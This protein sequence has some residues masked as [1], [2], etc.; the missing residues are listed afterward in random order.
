MNKVKNI[1]PPNNSLFP[2]ARGRAAKLDCHSLSFSLLVYMQSPKT[3]RTSFLPLSASQA[4]LYALSFALRM[5]LSVSASAANLLMP[6][7]SF[8]TAIWSSLKSKRN[9]G[10]SVM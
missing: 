10:S 5:L 6:S 2:S 1:P 9:S 7:R 3:R 8:S 4:S